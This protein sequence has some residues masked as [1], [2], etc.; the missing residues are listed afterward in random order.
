MA[1][2]K[3]RPIEVKDLKL[4][5]DHPD[6]IFEPKH[7]GYRALLHIDYNHAWFV[8][9]NDNVMTK[10][11]VLA[12]KIRR[13]F[14]VRNAI[15]DGEIVVPNPDAALTDFDR[16]LRA[17]GE[18]GYIA[19]DLLYVHGTNITSLPLIERKKEL[20]VLARSKQSFGVSPYREECGSGI[21]KLACKKG[22]EG[23][24]AKRKAD[25]YAQSTTWYK[26]LNPEYA[27]KKKARAA[28]FNR[29]RR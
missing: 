1:L 26:V 12:E 11:S 7:D 18:P 20:A 3:I 22:W 9:R 28:I 27:E 4:A 21:F 13:E 6:W 17:K 2:P 23:I 25:I 5:F 16:L 24:I 29:R 15:L 8:S 19:F 10:F 14:D